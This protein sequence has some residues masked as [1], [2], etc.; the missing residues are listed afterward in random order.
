MRGVMTR[1]LPLGAGEPCDEH[2]GAQSQQP[3]RPEA[4]AHG[5]EIND[6]GLEATPVLVPAYT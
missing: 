4:A 3:C 5:G 2:A 1:L 6:V